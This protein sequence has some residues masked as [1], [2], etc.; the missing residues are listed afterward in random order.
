VDKFVSRLAALALVIFIAFVGWFWCLSPLFLARGS[1]PLRFPPVE[2]E[3]LILPLRVI[4]GD[5]IQFAYLVLEK[6]GR[7]HGINAPEL[8]TAKGPAARDAL[9]KMLPAGP[10][11]ARLHGREKYGGA[12]I[13]IFGADGKS[14]NAAMVEQGHARPYQGRGPKE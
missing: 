1:E 6:R 3:C 9:Q 8:K 11:K 10:V 5:T 4:D 12:L 13:E 7:L 14:I 2:G